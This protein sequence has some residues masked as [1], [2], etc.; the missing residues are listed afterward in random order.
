MNKIQ[1]IKLLNLRGITEL[2]GI[3]IAEA[4]KQSGGEPTDKEM[5]EVNRQ[6][7]IHYI[8]ELIA[9]EAESKKQIER[10]QRK[11]T[12]LEKRDAILTSLENAGVDNW[13]GYHDA[14]SYDTEN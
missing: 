3:T 10:L 12:L 8:D 1:Y 4:V 9:T 5:S 13:E 7:M 11:I 14:L 2:K 6:A